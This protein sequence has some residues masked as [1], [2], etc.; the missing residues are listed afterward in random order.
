MFIIR[1]VIKFHKIQYIIRQIVFH[2]HGNIFDGT[3]FRFQKYIPLLFYHK[4]IT[5]THTATMLMR[6]D[7]KR[8]RAQK[9]SRQ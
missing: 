5:Q 2:N 1:N 8:S 6:Y 7:W 4:S 3:V 9:T